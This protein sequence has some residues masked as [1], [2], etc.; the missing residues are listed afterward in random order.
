MPLDF[1]HHKVIDQDTD[2]REGEHMARSGMGIYDNGI[3]RPPKLF[4]LIGCILV[5]FTDVILFNIIEVFA[6]CDHCPLPKKYRNF[7][8]GEGG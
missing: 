1:D 8:M 2:Q 5:P 3:H 4:W 7:G 6:N